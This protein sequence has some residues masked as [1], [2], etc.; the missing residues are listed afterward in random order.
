MPGR[1]LDVWEGEFRVA[2]LI[3][4]TLEVNLEKAARAEPGVSPVSALPAPLQLTYQTVVDGVTTIG[5]VEEDVDLLHVLDEAAGDG[6]SD[7][8]RGGVF[9]VD[10]PGVKIIHA[11]DGEGDEEG[12]LGEE[13]EEKQH[14]WLCDWEWLVRFER[15]S[16]V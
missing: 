1:L 9:S 2:A 10:Y 8:A 16:V 13:R 3:L 15:S 5:D 12:E 4:V 7:W 11:V 6:F 14:V